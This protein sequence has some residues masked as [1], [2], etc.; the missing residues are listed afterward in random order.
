M[1]Q[2]TGNDGMRDDMLAPGAA[3]CRVVRLPGPQ[4]LRVLP[5]LLPPVLRAVRPDRGRH[6]QVGAWAALGADGPGVPYQ[7]H[8]WMPS[9]EGWWD[10]AAR[11]MTAK[12]PH[13][14]D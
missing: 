13:G 5:R 10:G 7:V 8:D 1:V 4:E 11:K 12:V 14:Y 2:V 6:R 9:E 3:P